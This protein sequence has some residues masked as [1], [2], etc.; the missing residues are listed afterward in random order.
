MLSINDLIEKDGLYYEKFTDVPFTGN[1]VGEYQGK[2]RKGKREG[3]WLVY[4]ENGQL[5]SK[6]NYK[7]GILGSLQEDW[8]KYC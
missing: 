5:E 8:W 3:E 2:I 1:V 6:G 7:Y 4:Y